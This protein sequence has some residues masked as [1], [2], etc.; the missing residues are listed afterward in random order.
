MARNLY[1]KCIASGRQ[2]GQLLSGDPVDKKSV[3]LVAGDF[4]YLTFI[5]LNQAETTSIWPASISG[6]TGARCSIKASRSPSATRYAYQDAYAQS[7][8]GL[9]LYTPTTP[10]VQA[11]ADTLTFGMDLSTAALIGAIG[12]LG[13]VD[14]FLEMS[15]TTASGPETWLSEQI[16]ILNQLEDDGAV[17]AP[18]P[19][20]SYYTSAEV[21]ALA[22]LHYDSATTDL[23]TPAAVSIL[24]VPTGKVFVLQEV[25]R[26]LVAVTSAGAAESIKIGTATDDDGALPATALSYSAA[27]AMDRVMLSAPYPVAAGASVVVTITTGATASVATGKYIAVGYLIS[28]T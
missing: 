20:P 3:Q 4:A 21:L 24:T 18:T 19:A 7:V 5:L 26:Y 1:I 11:V 10:P 17:S 6:I 16:T 8:F 22:Q 28:A 2:S 25:H 9:D 27:G 12:V 23:T 15:I 14:A 13:S